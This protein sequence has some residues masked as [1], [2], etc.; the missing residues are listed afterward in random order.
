MMKMEG[1]RRSQLMAE[2]ER[3]RYKEESGMWKS[4]VER[5]KEVVNGMEMKMREK[6][7]EVDAARRTVREAE[8]VKDDAVSDALRER[9]REK[10]EKER[11]MMTITKMKEEHEKEVEEMKTKAMKEKDALEMK[12]NEVMVERDRVLATERE[13]VESIEERLHRARLEAEER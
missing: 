12:L 10:G 2:G 13:K 11:L 1:C 8:R 4:E 6:D 9:D 5:L 3:D 7:D